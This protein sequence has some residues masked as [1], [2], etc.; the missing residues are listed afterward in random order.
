[1]SLSGKAPGFDLGTPR[2]ESSHPSHLFGQI[3]LDHILRYL[4]QIMINNS[5]I[6][7]P[8]ALSP[9]PLASLRG[10]HLPVSVSWWPPAPGWWVAALLILVLTFAAG[11]WWWRRHWRRAAARRARIELATLRAT[12]IQ[13]NDFLCFARGLSRL[14]RRFALVQFPRRQVAGLTGEAWLSFLDAHGGKGHFRDGLGRLLIEAAYRPSGP[15]PTTELMA[16]VEGWINHN[17]DRMSQA[18]SDTARAVPATSS[19]PR[20]HPSGS[21]ETRI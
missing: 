11:H 10:Y 12:L 5:I 16:L 13:D 6:P 7:P 1:M 4:S 9:D 21:S 20:P 3:G 14:L 19:P 17:A 8:L 2:F 18:P 15:L